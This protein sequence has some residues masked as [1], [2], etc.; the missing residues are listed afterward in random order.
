MNTGE[1]KTEKN[2]DKNKSLLYKMHPNKDSTNK[3]TRN[4]AKTINY[5]NM[6]SI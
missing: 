2:K 5:D 4:M 6:N 1:K 3:S